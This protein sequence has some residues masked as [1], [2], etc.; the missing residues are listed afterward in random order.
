MVWKIFERILT[1]NSNLTTNLN[2]ILYKSIKDVHIWLKI[3]NW[4]I[5]HLNLLLVKLSKLPEKNNSK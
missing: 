5:H 4:K 1:E 3:K 2:F